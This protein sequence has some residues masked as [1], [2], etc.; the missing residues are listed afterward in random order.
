MNKLASCTRVRDYEVRSQSF[1]SLSL[2]TRTRVQLH[3]LG[4]RSRELGRL[5]CMPGNNS[6][7][8]GQRRDRRNLQ[9]TWLETPALAQVPAMHGYSA[10]P[11]TAA[12]SALHAV[13]ATELLFLRALSLINYRTINGLRS[14][15]RLLCRRTGG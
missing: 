13:L 1:L 7:L 5:K 14:Q 12:L 15:V 9:T 4:A 10:R 8:H 11:L 3:N 2:F 6:Y